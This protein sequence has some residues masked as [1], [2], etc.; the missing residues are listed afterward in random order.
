MAQQPRD[1]A[2]EPFDDT[3]RQWEPISDDDWA[4]SEGTPTPA[5]DEAA[6]RRVAHGS[7][8][9]PAGAAAGDG[10]GSGDGDWGGGWGTPERTDVRPHVVDR[11]PQGAGDTAPQARVLRRQR[12]L[13]RRASVAEDARGSFAEPPRERAPRPPRPRRRAR[14]GCLSFVLWIVVAGAA[15]L[16]ALRYLP[17][18]L[19]N[20]RAVPE[21]VSFVPLMLAPLAVCLVLAA[22]WH[23]RV[24]LVACGLAL[25]VT[26]WWHRGYF[27]P[28]ARVSDTA[29]ATIQTTASTDDGIMRIMTLNTKNG[30]ASAEEVVSLVRSQH[31][32]VLCLQELSTDFI[33]ELQAAGI[34]SVLPH[35]V[36]SDA[37]SAVNNGGRNGIWTLAPM[38]NTSGNLLSIDTSSMPAAS[39][40]VG[41]R[42]VR[43]VSVH[44]NS[45]VRGAQDLW[46]EGLS[47]IGSLSGYDH[48]YLI[49]GDFN[50]TWDHAR[51]RELLGTAFV[52]AGEQSGEGFHMTFPS[53]GDLP[54]LIEID[55]IVYAKNAG[56]VV[57]GLKAVEVTG[58]DHQALLG[59]LEVQ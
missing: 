50:S 30:G 10:P 51:F 52:D 38:S 48:A 47:V 43:V 46:D 1:N 54:S 24:L 33:A 28:T 44:P 49:M 29:T 21:L 41:G 17:S 56:I 32:E 58:S 25:A 27:L 16:L 12:P 19:A 36:I 15:A 13:T 53:Y 34:G 31:V 37:A 5:A 45:P 23:R 26:A 42:T 11:A 3:E 7:V 39:I 20:G 40:V 57:S 55:H 14:H 9:A 22:L 59:T 4:V 6:T 8:H 35:Y 2:R 18:S